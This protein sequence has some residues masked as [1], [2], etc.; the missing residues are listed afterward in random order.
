[1]NLIASV[2]LHEGM[3]NMELVAAIGGKFSGGSLVSEFFPAEP[4][5]ASCVL[6]RVGGAS[7]ASPTSMLL[8][9]D[10]MALDITWDDVK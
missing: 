8:I 4:S 2:K 6:L 3:S 10:M 9:P 1:M 5:N 7:R